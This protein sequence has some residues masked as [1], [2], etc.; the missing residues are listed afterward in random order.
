LVLSRRVTAVIAMP[1]R[2]GLKRLI[3]RR[4]L[5]LTLRPMNRH[6]QLTGM[7]T[8]WPPDDYVVLDGE[9]SVGPIYKTTIHGGP[10]WHRS[11]NTSPYPAP[12][13]D[14]WP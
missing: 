9:R 12:P 1:P 6:A 4:A 14:R 2:P 11:I 5:S 8:G 7:S 10:K 13:P 3:S